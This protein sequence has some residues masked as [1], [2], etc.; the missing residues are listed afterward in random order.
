MIIE[1][2]TELTLYKLNIQIDNKNQLTFKD[3]V[4]QDLYF[5]ITLQNQSKKFEDF[6]FQRQDGIVRVELPYNEA[7]EYTYCRYKNE[8]LDKYYYAYITDVIYSSNEM[9]MLKLKTDA[10]Q[11]YMFDIELLPSFIEREHVDDDTIGTH[12]YPENLEMGEFIANNLTYLNGTD[13]LPDTFIVLESTR[14]PHTLGD[15]FGGMSGGIPSGVSRF[16]YRYTDIDTMKTHIQ[17]IANLSANSI[18]A[19]INLYMIPSWLGEDATGGNYTAGMEINSNVAVTKYLE[20][21]PITQLGG[22]QT[23]NKYTPVNNKLLCY[24]YCYYLVSDGANGSAIYNPELFYNKKFQATVS[25]VISAGASVRL[26][27]EYYKGLHAG[28]NARTNC[29]NIE[30]LN[31]GKLPL[32]N[33]VTD[34]YTAWLNENALNIGIGKTKSYTDIASSILSLDLGG[35]LDNIMNAGTYSMQVSHQKHIADMTPLQLG[36]NSNSGDVSASLMLIDFSVYSMTIKPEYAKK[37]DG[38][39]YMY[40]YCVN[41]M[42]SIDINTRKKFNY[43]KT[44]GMNIKGDTVPQ[45]YIQDIKDMFNTGVSFWHDPNTFLEYD[46]TFKDNPII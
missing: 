46:P 20:A 17:N 19:I 41:E 12:T 7:K 27:P 39:F 2:T 4:A 35:T 26:I 40:G 24:P 44:I 23:P 18:N 29:N 10:W 38:L 6:T 25:G 37:I 36:G 33:W 32:L 13:S 11:T 21:P 1:P 42:K 43:I 16:L 3:K 31:M 45:I 5:R 8:S 28:A 15:A 9:T 14:N 34:S 30:G 22:M